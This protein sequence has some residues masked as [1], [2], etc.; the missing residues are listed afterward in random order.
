MR[1]YHSEVPR[2]LTRHAKDVFT[3]VNF[4]SGVVAIQYLMD[5]HPRRAGYAVIVGFLGGD[6]LDGTVARMTKTSNRFGAELDSMVDHFVHVVVPGLIVYVVYERAG[7]ELLGLV[8]FGVLVG[9]ATL[10]HARLAAVQFDFPLC[11]VGLPR[12]ISGFAA[13]SMALS[14]V[15]GSHMRSE[16]WLGFSMVVVLSALNLV[17]IPY[18]THRGKRAMQ[19]AAKFCVA[20][21]IVT[22]VITYF[23]DRA[24]TFDVFLFWMVGYAA[25]GWAP[26]KREERRGFYE[27]YRRWSAALTS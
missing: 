16:H 1:H 9:T 14:H 12:T 24:W 8:A 21:F 19:P 6:L 5:G 13:M 27:E 17:P 23:V 20:L 11:W 15:F 18:M 26:L 4:V 10:R 22:P 25:M 3:L 2:Q 7:Y